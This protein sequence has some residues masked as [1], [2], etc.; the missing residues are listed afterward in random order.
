MA[1]TLILADIDVGTLARSL[2]IAVLIVL[3]FGIVRFRRTRARQ[4][5]LLAAAMPIDPPPSGPTL[6]AVVES[7]AALDPAT[8]GSVEVPDGCT[9]DGRPVTPEVAAVVLADALARSGLREAG[10]VR[11]PTAVVVHCEPSAGTGGTP[12]K[13]PSGGADDDRDARP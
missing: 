8:G 9:V 10:R 2:A 7:I 11:T 3:P 1:A 5:A 12:G 4:R 13:E 6:E